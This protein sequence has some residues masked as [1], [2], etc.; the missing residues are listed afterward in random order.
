MT[1]LY[2]HWPFCLSKC[3]YCD[4]NSHVH[5][6]FSDGDW[7]DALCQE[8]TH[9][10]TLTGP[11]R[12][13]SVFFGGGTPSLMGADMVDQV[14]TH[15]RTLWD[16]AEDAEVTLEANP[17]SVEKEKFRDFKGAG[18][19]RLSVGIQSLRP[20]SLKFL[21]RTHGVTEALNALSVAQ[22]T[23]DRYSF[24]LI[25]ALPH[26]TPAFWEQELREAC[27]LTRGHLSV[28][29]L[30]IE[31]G[32]AFETAYNRGDFALPTDVVGEHLYDLTQD[33][34]GAHGLGAYEISNHAAPHQE[35]RHNVLY[36]TYGDYIGVGPGAHGR[37]T[38]DG[39]KH[40]TKNFRAPETWIQAVRT[41]GHALQEIT[42]LDPETRAFEYLMMGLRLTTGIDLG[43]FSRQ[44]ALDL[45]AFL[46]PTRLATLGDE[47][48][49]TRSPTHLT[50]TAK[51]RKV[52][53]SILRYLV[54]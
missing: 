23:F 13:E 6:A 36:W 26:Q 3:P 34:L 47:G 44:T 22:E 33:I 5:R 14:L 28:Y 11:R 37:L 30:T 54:A 4:F 25:Y 2:I 7:A 46:D 20:E 32:T 29:Q 31:P 38:L 19:N 50:C 18:I 9:A 51:G 40:A 42:P 1:G 35:C 15:A 52:L 12:I 16:F 45:E 43:D 8:L 27:A 17:N 21:G 39:L 53:N 49:L 48:L 10:R 41:H 24:D